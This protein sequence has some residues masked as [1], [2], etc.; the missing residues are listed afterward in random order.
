MPRRCGGGPVFGR[1]SRPDPDRDLAKMR[2]RTAKIPTAD[3]LNWAEQA[4][5][6][7]GR[8]LSDYRRQHAP[9]DLE[10]AIMG[11]CALYAVLCDLRKRSS[12][13]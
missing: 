7:I 5:M 2:S 13:V 8:H 4:E 12:G 3:L 10:E 11:A 9:D 1:P 6:G